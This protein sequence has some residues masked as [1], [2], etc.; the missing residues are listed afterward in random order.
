MVT[1]PANMTAQATSPASAVV[2]YANATATDALGVVAGP[3]CLPASGSTFTVG[4]TTV[5][6]SA[7][8]AAGNTGTA[9][10]LVRV[11]PI[12][13][14]TVGPSQTVTFSN[15]MV[16]GNV[17]VNGGTLILTNGT[18]VSGNVQASSGSITISGGSTVDGNL[19]LTGSGSV[20][21][22]TGTVGGNLLTGGGSFSIG[23]G[24]VLEGQFQI[25][26]QP[27][28]GPLST[29]CGAH[30]N[31]NVQSSN[32]ASPVDIGSTPGVCGQPD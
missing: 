5:T 21:I 23:P 10:F 14:T 16:G 22:G 25:S 29:M 2:T 19:Q 13:N 3:S 8:D 31:K 28:G 11:N 27:A 26:N 20:S 1:P 12:G 17:T 30:V 24:A 7:T 32:N 6:C 9:T 15:G 18:Q 4:T